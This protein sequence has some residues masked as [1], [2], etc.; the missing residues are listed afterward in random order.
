MSASQNPSAAACPILDTGHHAWLSIG[1]LG[2]VVYGSLVP[3]DFQITPMTEALGRYVAFFR[4]DPGRGSRT[5]WAINVLL[6]IPLGYLLTGT[7]SVDR[8]PTSGLW[9]ALVVVPACAALSAAIEFA[10]VFTPSR[11][12][13]PSDVKAETLGAVAGVLAWLACGQAVTN[14]ARRL[15]SGSPSGPVAR[16]LPG[17]LIVLVLVHVMPLDLTIRPAEIAW[18]YREGRIRLLPAGAAPVWP[19]LRLA[20]DAAYFAPVGLL[21]SQRPGGGRWAWPG[22]L[23]LGLALAGLIEGLQLF[24]VSRATIAFD[25]FAGALAVLAGWGLGRVLRPAL[26][27][28][29]A[30]RAT[31]LGALLVTWTIALALIHWWP[32]RF[33]IDQAYLADRLRRISWVPFEDY[34]WQA[35][36]QAF[37]QALHKALLFAPVGVLLGILEPPSAAGRA[38]SVAVVLA[39][40]IGLE[41]GQIALFG[42]YPGITDVLIEGV[43]AW[44]G[45]VA[46]RRAGAAPRAG[47]SPSWRERSS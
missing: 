4:L 47:P 13:S 15:W 21:L 18:K 42:R 38:R 37:E 5:D 7:A 25:I 3:F 19:I 41:A 26:A 43:G 39:L 35:P 10:Q 30:I 34:Y 29:P 27:R 36:Y 23:G 24:V 31:A 46:A 1:Y 33:S 40:S 2:V 17:Y 20:W 8:R 28:R 16:L 12:P 14:W 11:T 44:I 45:W 6:F 9:A 22:V 32:Y